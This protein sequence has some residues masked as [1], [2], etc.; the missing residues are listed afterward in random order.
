VAGFISVETDEAVVMWWGS[1]V[2]DGLYWPI[3]A[4]MRAGSGG[5]GQ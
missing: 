1:S 2:V 3:W 4:F 5:W